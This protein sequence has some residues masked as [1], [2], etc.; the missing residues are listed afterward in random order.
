MKKAKYEV[1][2]TGHD[3]PIEFVDGTVEAFRIWLRKSD[4][5]TASSG[6]GFA[7]ETDARIA[8]NAMHIALRVVGSLTESQ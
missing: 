4:G 6:Q 3:Q 5:T 2:W 1:M 8:F 7:K